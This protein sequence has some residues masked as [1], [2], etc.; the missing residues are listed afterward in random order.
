MASKVIEDSSDSGSRCIGARDDEKVALR[1]ELRHGETF[2][3]LGIFGVEEI[4][5]EVLSVA[6]FSLLSS[7]K[8]LGFAE[9]HENLTVADEVGKEDPV[10]AK[11][12]DD[13]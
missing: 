10:K 3:C 1:P 7:L 4:V 13:G 8:G 5:E 12:V 2:A 9:V 11:F 6:V